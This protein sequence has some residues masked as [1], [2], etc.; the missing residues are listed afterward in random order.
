MNVEFLDFS[1][2]P[3]E[4]SEFGD[5]EHLNYKGAKVFSEWFNTIITKG[6]LL[7]YNPR[8]TINREIAELTKKKGYN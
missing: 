6:V 1:K 5:L 8:E 4:N 3:L 7:E 2:F